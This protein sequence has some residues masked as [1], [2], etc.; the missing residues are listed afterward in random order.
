MQSRQAPGPAAVPHWVPGCKA[1]AWLWGLMRPAP[2][3]G[4]EKKSPNPAEAGTLLGRV[5][6]STKP[7]RRGKEEKNGPPLEALG[8]RVWTRARGPHFTEP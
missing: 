2:H 3:G 8:R 7:R 4:K 6:H 5:T 1:E